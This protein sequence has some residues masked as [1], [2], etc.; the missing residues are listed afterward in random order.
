MPH[1]DVN[2]MYMD[3]EKM[4]FYV[5]QITACS[6]WW[7]NLT[8]VGKTYILVTAEEVKQDGET[9]SRFGTK[10]LIWSSRAPNSI[11]Q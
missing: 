2:A 6:I 1:F 10:C 5:A 3:M 7:S 4:Y 11:I 9:R 8:W